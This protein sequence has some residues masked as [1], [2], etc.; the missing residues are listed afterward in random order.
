MRA[1]YHRGMIKALMRGL[2]AIA[3]ALT[4]LASSAPAHAAET[5]PLAEAVASL[6]PAVESRDGYSRSA[7]RHWTSR[8]H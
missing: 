5:L 3:V 8:P 7:F 6:Q 2:T 4:P 1:R